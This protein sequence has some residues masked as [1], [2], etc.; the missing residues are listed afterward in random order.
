MR[1]F[2]GVRRPNERGFSLIELIMVL[3]LAGILGAVAL[4]RMGLL[5]GMNGPAFRDELRSTLQVAQK[6][7]MATRR[8]VCATVSGNAVSFSLD[9]REPDTFTG[10]ILCSQDIVLPAPGKACTS[11]AANRICA[12]AGMSITNL[13]SGL[14]FD[15]GARPYTLAGA[16]RTTTLTV[17]V[18]DGGGELWPVLVEGET[19]L[20]H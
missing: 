10:A 20:V 2:D 9:P 13:G 15:P 5:T 3:L 14:A 12:P 17:N 11:P 16:V 7:A 4:P 1:R 6:T 18:V 19:G 8:F